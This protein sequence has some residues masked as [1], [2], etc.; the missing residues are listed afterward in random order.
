MRLNEEKYI[1]QAIESVLE[2]SYEKFELII[3]DDFSTD[4]SYNICKG[5]A[6][7]SNKIKL[8]KNDKKGK[9]FAF[10][11]GYKK[12]TGELICYFAGDDMMTPDSLKNRSNF[13]IS[14]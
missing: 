6:E 7:K 14:S 1:S 3:I 2:Q 4:T 8:I 5:Y 11:N 10:N 9:V 12:S 13:I